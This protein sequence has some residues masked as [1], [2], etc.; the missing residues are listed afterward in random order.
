MRVARMLLL[1][2]LMGF[3]PASFGFGQTWTQTSAPSNLWS[4]VASSADGT[5]L[6]ASSIPD[7][8]PHS[9]MKGGIWISRDSGATWQKTSA[10]ETGWGRV[11]CS[12]NGNILFAVSD[13][14]LAYNVSFCVSTN[15][16]LVWTS[17]NISTS[18]N[19]GWGESFVCSADGSKMA[20]LFLS[21]DRK[22][23]FLCT[24]SE[25]GANLAINILTNGGGHAAAC[26]ADGHRLVL[27]G[28]NSWIS[29]NAGVSWVVT[30]SLPVE[31]VAVAASA[32]GVRLIGAPGFPNGIRNAIYISTNGGFAWT[33]TT[34]PLTNWIAV[35][36]SA[37]GS[38]LA[39][40]GYVVP[41]SGPGFI[42]EPYYPI[43]TSTNSGA[44]WK[45]NNVPTSLGKSV[46]FSSDG[47]KLV[48][49][50]HGGGIWISQSE[51]APS[52]QIMPTQSDLKLS[53]LVPSTNFVLQQ[54]ADLSSW[55]DLTNQ[56][57]LNLT[58][59]Q[60]E[61]AL[62]LSGSNSFFRLKTP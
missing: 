9:V 39:A 17:T 1:T 33:E 53:W 2:G 19:L 54:S 43:Y 32:D 52:M 58:N 26:S 10:P 59:L 49:A 27:V 5:K 28:T 38:K 16:G 30:N 40:V 18:P 11:A 57:V 3:L 47:T 20:A 23:N 42:S 37:D 14:Y 46:A 13:Y 25:F 60:D 12:A 15:S 34:A 35:A 22:T 4:C 6:I 24:S 56:P 51:P 48:A 44:T 31:I 21:L 61:V 7:A 62:P 36:S 55:T 29:T 45:L 41:P 50:I 8:T